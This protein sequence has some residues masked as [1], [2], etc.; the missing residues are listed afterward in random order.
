MTVSDFIQ[1]VIIDNQKRIVIT[2]GEAVGNP[3]EMKDEFIKLT[4]DS[5]KEEYISSEFKDNMQIITV[6]EGTEEKNRELIEKEHVNGAKVAI[7]TINLQR[8]GIMFS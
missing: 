7:S 3:E 6:K 8:G 2:F 4:E 1:S 5:L